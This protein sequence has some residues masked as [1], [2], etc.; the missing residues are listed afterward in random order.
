MYPNNSFNFNQTGNFTNIPP[1]KIEFIN[2]LTNQNYLLQNQIIINNNLIQNLMNEQDSIF[3]GYNTENYI[4]II[5]EATSGLTI[6]IR[7]RYNIPI[8]SLL[9]I[10]MTRIGKERNLNDEDINFSYNGTNIDKHDDKKISHPDF[11]M[12][13]N[14]RIRVIDPNNKIGRTIFL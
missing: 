5:F 7:V 4:N 12:L 6:V 8:K 9:Y 11:N 14:S 3:Y 1:N 2:Q 10:Y 13:D